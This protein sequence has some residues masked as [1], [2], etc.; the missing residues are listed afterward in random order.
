[1]APEKKTTDTFVPF[2]VLLAGN[3]DQQ[4]LDPL[5]KMKEEEEKARQ[6]A[7]TIID[8]AERQAEGVL[9]QAEKD[10]H[11]KGFQEGLQKG[12]SEGLARYTEKIGE[13]DKTIAM[14][15]G[16]RQEV[17]HNCETDLRH[18]VIAMV[19]H[20]VHHEVSVN[21]R[22]IQACLHNA[23]QFV[24]DSGIIRIKLH[25]DDFQR[26]REASLEDPELLG[27]YEQV[28]LIEDASVQQGGCLLSSDFGEI[29]ATINDF[30]DRLAKAIDKAFLEALAKTE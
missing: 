16:E 30:Q 26:I 1:M 15:A 19:N 6:K 11:E 12:E 29:D 28:D 22:V 21:P 24:A 14:L 5:R 9:L 3:G 13:L 20:L 7:K 23:I 8:D 10:G 25:P 17:H 4:T 2:G 27:R 18:L